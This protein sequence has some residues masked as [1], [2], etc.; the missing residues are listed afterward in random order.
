MFCELWLY[1]VSPEAA[2]KALQVRDRQRAKA[3]L[4]RFMGSVERME[5]VVGR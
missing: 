3:A 2:E 4:D 5:Q 1:R